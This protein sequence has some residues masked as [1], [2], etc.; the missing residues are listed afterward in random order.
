[1]VKTD[2]FAFNDDNGYPECEVC[3]T[4][5]CR[6]GECVWYKSKKQFNADLL[7]I[8]GTTDLD[9]IKERYAAGHVEKGE[10]K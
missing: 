8:N 2:C 3:M 10:N 1:M 6:Q 5:Q 9:E 4:L 7:R